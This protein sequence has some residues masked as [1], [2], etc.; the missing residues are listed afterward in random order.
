MVIRGEATRNKFWALIILPFYPAASAQR[1]TIGY[2]KSPP[3][4]TQ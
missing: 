3:M 4:D 1:P 2:Y